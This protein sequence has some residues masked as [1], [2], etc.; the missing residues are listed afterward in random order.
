[1]KELTFAVFFIK[2]E[3]GLNHLFMGHSTGNKFW[4]VPKG[5][6]ENDEH[7][8]DSAIREVF[9]ETGFIVKATDLIDA[10]VFIYNSSK[11]MHVFVYKGHNFPDPLTSYC[12]STFTCPH[13]GRERP[14]LD[15]FKYV[16]FSKVSEHC[17]KS[18]NKVFSKFI[19]HTGD[20]H[21]EN[22]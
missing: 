4:D 10:G 14:E 1:M 15:D 3:G 9:E 12:S 16:E 20:K 6:A 2:K 8:I 13:T 21:E 18:F 17:A 22:I 19:E 7:P 5:G 11:N